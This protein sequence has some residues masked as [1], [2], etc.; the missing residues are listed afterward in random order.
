MANELRTKTRGLDPNLFG[1]WWLSGWQVTQSRVEGHSSEALT[2]QTSD[3]TQQLTLGVLETDCPPKIWAM[4]HLQVTGGLWRSL[5]FVCQ[6]RQIVKYWI[7]L[8]YQQV[9]AHKHMYTY[10]RGCRGTDETS[11][12]G[13]KLFPYICTQRENISVIIFTVMFCFVVHEVWNVS[14]SLYINRWEITNAHVHLKV[15]LL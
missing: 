12:Q 6:D 3:S 2:Q 1:Y 14:K 13:K 7:L 15:F 4:M 8:I 11:S 5:Y 10:L 9:Y